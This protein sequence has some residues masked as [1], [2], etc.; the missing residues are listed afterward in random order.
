MSE[1]HGRPPGGLPSARRVTVV[2]QRI[3]MHRLQELV[4]LHRLGINSREVARLLGMSPNTER[5]YRVALVRAT[6][7]GGGA[8]ALPP[9][10]QLAAAVQTHRG[11]LVT[12][13]QSVSTVERWREPVTAMLDRRAT[14]QAIYDALR[15]EHEYNGSLSA[16]KR[17]CLRL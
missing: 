5:D 7:L 10:E 6:L 11:P 4:R 1:V 9:L 13:Q 3:D 15:L 16:V 14:P 8:A 12:P 2:A 17:F